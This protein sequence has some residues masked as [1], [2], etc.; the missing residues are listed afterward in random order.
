MKE[1]YLHSLGAALC[2]EGRLDE[3]IDAFRAALALEDAAY[4][5]YNLSLAFLGKGELEQAVDELTRAIGI[6]PSAPEYYYERSLIRRRTGD[7]E[8]AS[9]DLAEAVAMDPGYG[10]INEI[11]TALERVRQRFGTP[12]VLE[13]RSCPIPDCPAYCCH[14]TGPMVRHGV[15][16]GAWKLRS[17]RALL[18]ER[19]LDAEDFLDRL[20]FHG[21]EHIL[22]LAPPNYIIKEGDGR[23][24]FSPKKGRRPARQKPSRG[25]P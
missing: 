9:A 3:A 16:L 1:K 23:F 13:N 5:H 14:F 6:H 22:R 10:R 19:G 17:V 20:P 11:K 12:A 21:E 8:R 24:I 18:K 25:P 7:H 4:T 15:S 2:E